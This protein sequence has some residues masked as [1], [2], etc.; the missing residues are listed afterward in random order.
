LL[1]KSVREAF[2]QWRLTGVW[3]TFERA[4]AWLETPPHTKVHVN[5]FQFFSIFGYSR[6]G[7]DDR[8]ASFVSLP[9][10][11]FKV[12]AESATKNTTI[13][14]DEALMRANLY[15]LF[16][17]SRGCAAILPRIAGDIIV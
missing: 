6:H 2:L 12:F 1:A 3:A 17:V 16:M 8:Q 13:S 7:S 10:Y 14:A 5:R 11:L 4:F 15:E 9:L